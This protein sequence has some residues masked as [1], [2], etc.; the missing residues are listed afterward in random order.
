MECR[1][2]P[3]DAIMVHGIRSVRPDLHLE[4]GVRALARNAFDGNTNRGQIFG[5]AAIVRGQFNE[6]ANPLCREFHL[7][8]SAVSHQR[9]NAES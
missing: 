4:D 1:C 6:I 8:P 2:F 3:R 9:R 7:E 5:K